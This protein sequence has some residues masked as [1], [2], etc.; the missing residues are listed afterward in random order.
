MSLKHRLIRDLP[1]GT[2]VAGVET[3]HH[4]VWGKKEYPSKTI[5]VMCASNP[6]D[7]NMFGYVLGFLP[8]AKYTFFTKV[9]LFFKYLTSG[10]LKN[11]IKI[12]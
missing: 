8:N 11:G 10:K 5:T 12:I 9:V 6:E 1:K 4:N 3:T 7:P 2:L